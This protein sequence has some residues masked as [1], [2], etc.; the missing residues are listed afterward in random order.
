MRKETKKQINEERMSTYE[1]FL[2]MFNYSLKESSELSDEKNWYIIS[3]NNNKIC[4]VLKRKMSDGIFY[5]MNIKDRDKLFFCNNENPYTFTFKNFNDTII[6][7]SGDEEMIMLGITTSRGVSIIM[8]LDNKNNFVINHNIENEISSFYNYFNT[9]IKVKDNSYEYYKSYGIYT[10]KGNKSYMLKKYS[11]KE[12]NGLVVIENKFKKKSRYGSVSDNESYQ[13]I[14]TKPFCS[15]LKEHEF[16]KNLLFRILYKFNSELNFK[17]NTD[18]IAAICYIFGKE[19]I[20]SYELFEKFGK[21][22][23]KKDLTLTKR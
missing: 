8:K 7:I 21:E 18:F 14:S 9:V 19:E 23:A 2:E 5:S 22:K 11:L 3:N 20:Y 15:L 13:E 1:R 12:E 17:N 6:K 16:G 10:D 4:G